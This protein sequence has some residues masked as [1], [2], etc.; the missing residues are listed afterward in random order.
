[1]ERGMIIQTKDGA[2]RLNVSDIQY[3]EIYDHDL[4]FHADEKD[5][6]SNMTMRAI[7]KALE[8]YNFSR[9]NHCYLINLEHVEGIEDGCAVIKGKKLQL[10]RSRKNEFMKDLKKYWRDYLKI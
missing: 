7:E 2:I 4:V 6:V 3:I 10:S 8:K 9:G 5:Y 1:M